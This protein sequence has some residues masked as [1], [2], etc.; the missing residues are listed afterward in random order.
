LSG[1]LLR[2]PIALRP[3]TTAELYKSY[4]QHMQR[5]ADVRHA[6]AVLQ[7]DQETYLPAK[8]ARFRAQQL[9]TLAQIAHEWFSDEAWPAPCRT[10]WAKTT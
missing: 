8:G 2:I 6:H 4:V 5:I 1:S 7:W 10:C 9:S 3:M